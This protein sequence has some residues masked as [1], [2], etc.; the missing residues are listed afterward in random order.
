MAVPCV[1][2]LAQVADPVEHW[3]PRCLGRFGK[4]AL[5]PCVCAPCSDR[6][7]GLDEELVRATPEAVYR[8]ILGVRGRPSHRRVE[9]LYEPVRGTYPLT[10]VRHVPGD[11]VPVRMELLSAS[12]AQAMRQIIFSANNPDA[13]D[14]LHVPVSISTQPERVAKFIRDAGLV[15]ATPLR[16]YC[17]KENI[18]RIERIL[19]LGLRGRWGA[20]FFELGPPGRVLPPGD[21]RSNARIRMT[22]QAGA[23]Y[24]RSILKLAF[25]YTLWAFRWIDGAAAEFEGVRRTLL[26][27]GN[28]D[29]YVEAL[30]PLGCAGVPDPTRFPHYWLKAAHV[31][32]HLEAFVRML[33]GLAWR[34][35]LGVNPSR[36]D[37]RVQS[38]HVACYTRGDPDQDGIVIGEEEFK[39]RCETGTRIVTLEGHEE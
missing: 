37:S 14:L 36:L 26:S 10:F 38:A 5:L 21:P 8:K 11:P 12:S 23:H 7:G 35:R 39:Y 19:Q 18:E 1:Y 27:Q 33:S 15:R 20:P 22:L 6:L 16:V 4:D 31:G 13:D 17:E 28:P 25:E 30:G 2:C 32:Q 34:V 9:P 3:L 29:P 24:H